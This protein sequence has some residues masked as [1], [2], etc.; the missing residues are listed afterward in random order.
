MTDQ[1]TTDSI[2]PSAEVSAVRVTDVRFEHRHD[3]L[4]IGSAQPR[5]SWL[6]ATEL[7]GWW[8]SGYEIEAHSS[9]GAIYGQTGQIHADQSVLVA[10]PFAPLTSRQSLLVRV[11]VWGNDQQVSD[12]SQSFPLEVGLLNASDW[13][14]RFVTPTWDEDTSIMQPGPLLRREFSIRT[15]LAKARLYITALGV[16]EAQIN[17]RVVGDH[18]LDPGWTS[19]D[20]RLR[21]QIFDVTRLLHD[22]QN[23]LGAMLGDGWYRGRLGFGGGQRNNYGDRLALL[24]Q[25]ELTYA[26]GS[27]ERLISDDSWKAASGPILTNDIYD[28]ETYDARLERDGWATA[29]YDDSHWQSVR[30]L[31]RDL[32]RL[33]APNGP[34]VR[35]IEE[36]APVAITKSPSGR[37][38]IDFGQNLVGWLRIRVQ[39]RIGQTI[40]LRHAEV[41][42]HGELGTRPLRHAAATDRYI[43]KGS[44]IETWEPR[45]TFH[46]FRYAEIQGWPGELRTDDVRA[47]VCHSDMQRTGWFECSDPL[48]NRL[49]ENIVWSMRGNFFDIPTD[50]PQRDERLGWTGDIQVFAPTAC[51]LYDTAGF[52]ESWLADLA[53]EQQ[54]ADGIVPVVVPNVLG[55]PFPAAA[56]GDAAAVVPWVLYQRYGDTHILE[57]QFDSMRS[58]VDTLAG[59]AGESLLW[60]QGFQFGDWL[61]PTAAP[62]RPWDAKA[63]RPLVATA[64]FARSAELVGQAAGILGKTEQQA[65]YSAL[66]AAIRAAFAREYITPSGRML[67]DATTAY[68]LALEFGLLPDADQRQRAAQRL[69]EL[70]RAS[71]YHI[72]TGFVGTPLIC[73]ALCNAAAYQ[74]A[75]LL[76]LQRECPSW[77]YPVTMGATTIWE[78]WD[79]MLPDGSINPGEMTSFNHYALG[80]VADW[81]HRTVAGLAPAEP[82]Y[83]RMAIQ[84]RPGGGLT[85]AKA[86]HH[87]PYGMAEC[88]WQITDGTI[89]VNVIIPANTSAVVRLPGTDE[90]PIEIASGSH[91]WSY[92]YQNP[93]TRP[94]LTLD[95]PISAFID[96]PQTW[97]LVLKTLAAITP[98]PFLAGSLISMDRMPLRQ[99]LTKQ[100]NAAAMI[101]ALEAALAENT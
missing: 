100:P 79:S 97:A 10:W 5:I 92:H 70:V 42:E 34:P 89:T 19:Y 71:G 86:R 1:G 51:F 91:R 67:S 80:A 56:W 95:Q 13:S 33:V 63:D 39:G 17:G 48:I 81:L 12:W 77:L 31:D 26:D 94:P 24:A 93:D 28:G 9:D 66:A 14:A 90:P 87:T 78:R 27:S 6:I 47:I 16:Y 58:W 4:G 40:T 55:N 3:T 50:C 54:A 45:F 2:A 57:T 20:H 96:S 84:P 99:A 68:A 82:G 98:S 64:Y 49:H 18:V 8:Q 62:E 73:D 37:T 35:R 29:E 11:R 85:Y 69:V 72:N 25:L 23:V 52:L 75:Y 59:L 15:D 36:I 7:D 30:L 41:L 21:Y 38:I 53:A 46:G 22:G 88:A 43:L 65:T 83:R 32:T 76:L 74:S 101:T 60:N 44:A 61:D